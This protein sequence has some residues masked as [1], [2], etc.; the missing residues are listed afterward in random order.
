ML[1]LKAYLWIAELDQKD[2]IASATRLSRRDPCLHA[3]VNASDGQA[4]RHT[5]SPDD[6]YSVSARRRGS[7]SNDCSQF[8][9]IG[10]LIVSGNVI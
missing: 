5:G 9:F 7:P 1:R 8:G 10:Q 6:L 2:W 3:A 4:F